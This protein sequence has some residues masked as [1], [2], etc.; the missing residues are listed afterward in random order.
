MIRQPP[1]STRIDTLFPSTTL[2]R[3]SGDPK[4][5]VL[6]A[7]G[8][9]EHAG[10]YGPVAARLTAAGYAVYAVDHMGHGQSDGT[11]GYVPRFALYVQGMAA[12][13]GRVREAWPRSEEH[14]SDLQ[15][16]LRH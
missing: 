15:S 7:H 10:R 5:V 1:R 13:I 9:A 4:A 6:L 3:S 14:T 12:L 11:M 2:F 8:Y 16:L